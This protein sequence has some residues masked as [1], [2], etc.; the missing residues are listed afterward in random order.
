MPFCDFMT[1]SAFLGQSTKVKSL[2]EQVNY[3]ARVVLDFKK[4]IS[5]ISHHILAHIFTK[6]VLMLRVPES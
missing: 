2:N 5:C 6:V 3:V 1:N 4:Q